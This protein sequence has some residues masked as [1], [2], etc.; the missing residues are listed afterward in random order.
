MLLGRRKSKRPLSTDSPLHLVLRSDF[1]YGK[2]SLLKH[3]PRIEKIIQR[4]ANKFAIRVYQKAIVGN[5]IH[6][7][8]KGKKRE[9]IQ[10]FF[11]IVAGHIAQEIL[12]FAPLS[13]DEM[14]RRELMSSKKRNKENK[15]WQTRIY[16]R[17]VRWGKDF[18]TV[19]AYVIQN[20]L[21]ALG[22]I[23]YKKRTYFKSS[24]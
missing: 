15:F 6:L 22:L 12:K 8:V 18:F 21:E 13:A 16:S 1:A 11:R 24:A 10:N 19:K 23:P 7:L 20:G 4:S 17:L 9:Q 3:R 5:H 14:K 2:R